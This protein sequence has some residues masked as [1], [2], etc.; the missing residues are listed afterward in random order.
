MTGASLRARDG[1]NARPHSI[2]IAEMALT[3]TLEDACAFSRSSVRGS[4]RAKSLK[5]H[6]S[7]R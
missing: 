2:S 3:E 5:T 4:P 6:V 1:F 7:S